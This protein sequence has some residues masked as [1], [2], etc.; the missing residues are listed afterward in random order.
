LYW[1]CWTL[2]VATVT[3]VIWPLDLLV[4]SRGPG[5]HRRQ[6]LNNL[7]RTSSQFSLCL[8]LQ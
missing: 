8:Q 6:Q 4:G 5:L 7:P 2:P 1:L 3:D